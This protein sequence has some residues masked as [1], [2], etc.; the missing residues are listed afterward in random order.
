MACVQKWAS[1]HQKSLYILMSPY[2]L[3]SGKNYKRISSFQKGIAFGHNQYH[4]RT[5]H[6]NPRVVVCRTL[7]I[8]KV[9]TRGG[10]VLKKIT[11]K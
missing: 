5:K 6:P 7:E 9:Q 1:Y 11:W 4:D 3:L 8:L 2:A 10:Q